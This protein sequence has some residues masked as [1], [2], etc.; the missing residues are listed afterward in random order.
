L[1]LDADLLDGHEFSGVTAVEIA[2]LHE[3]DLRI[4]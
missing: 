1:S 4:Q 3:R 2:E